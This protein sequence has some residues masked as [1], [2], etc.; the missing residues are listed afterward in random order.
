MLRRATQDFRDLI[1]RQFDS[2]A[3]TAIIRGPR[4]VVAA[5]VKAQKRAPQV[6][7]A[8]EPKVTT[9]DSQPF[10]GAPNDSIGQDTQLTAGVTP[11]FILYHPFPVFKWSTGQDVI[12]SA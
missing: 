7:V 1:K 2:G 9:P 5:G 11:S 8:Q 10:D 4:Q 6:S 3:I 12:H